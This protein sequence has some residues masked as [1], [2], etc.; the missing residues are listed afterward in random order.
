MTVFQI[1]QL[2]LFIVRNMPEFVETL[3]KIAELIRGGVPQ[4]A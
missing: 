3:K 1:I 4:P 2:V